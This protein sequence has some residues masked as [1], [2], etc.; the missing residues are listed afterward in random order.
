[1]PIGILVRKALYFPHAAAVSRKKCHLRSES[2][3]GDSVGLHF[4]TAYLQSLLT[5][6][7][8]VKNSSVCLFYTKEN[9]VSA[10]TA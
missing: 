7:F 6:V 2:K 9:G 10:D 4:T 5:T 8:P 1:M 3:D